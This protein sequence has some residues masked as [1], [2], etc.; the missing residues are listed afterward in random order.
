MNLWSVWIAWHGFK[1][2]REGGKWIKATKI[3][4]VQIFTFSFIYLF[5]MYGC[6]A[7]IYVCHMH[8]WLPQNPGDGIRSPGVEVKG[9]YEP[10]CECQELNS[11]P[12]EEPMFL[13]SEPSQQ[14]IYCVGQTG[15][16]LSLSASVS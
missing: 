1:N 15:L 2:G 16:D 14:S 9:G 13:A 6:S 12:L 4:E 11:G 5:T 3:L 10:P 8:A 7:F